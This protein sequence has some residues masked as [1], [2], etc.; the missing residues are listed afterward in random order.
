MRFSFFGLLL[1]QP[2]EDEQEAARSEKVF[3]TQWHI[4]ALAVLSGLFCAGGVV[5]SL[6]SDQSMAINLILISMAILVVNAG[7]EWYQGLKARALNHFF[8]ITVVVLAMMNFRV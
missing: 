8:S 1:M 3:E 6:L 4:V 7:F 2:F 5:M